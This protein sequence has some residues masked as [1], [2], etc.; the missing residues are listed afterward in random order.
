MRTSI[1]ADEGYIFTNGE[2]YGTE[3]YLAEGVSADDFKQITLEEYNQ[4]M[5]EQESE[6]A[7]I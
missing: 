6:Q 1:K 2:T 3:I 4:L 5:S 7:Q